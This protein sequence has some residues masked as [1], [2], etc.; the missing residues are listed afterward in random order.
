[1][2]SLKDAHFVAENEL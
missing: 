1:V 2:S